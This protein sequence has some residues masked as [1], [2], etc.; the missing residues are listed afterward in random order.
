MREGIRWQNVVTFV[1]NGK[2]IELVNP[3]PNDKLI[4]YLKYKEN[5]H[6]TKLSCGEGGCGACT[7]VLCHRPQES[8]PEVAVEGSKTQENVTYRAVNACLFPVCALDG[9]EVITVEGIGSL[10]KGLHPI[11]QRLVETNGTQCGY[12]T[13][14]WVMNMYELLRKNEHSK[15]LITRKTVES[16]FD[17]NLCRCTG[18]RPILKAFHSFAI[19]YDN[20]T[21]QSSPALCY[22]GE[23]ESSLQQ[24]YHHRKDSDGLDDWIV[25]DTEST[26]GSNVGKCKN[27]A[28]G[29]ACSSIGSYCD[30]YNDLE[31]LLSF[32]SLELNAPYNTGNDIKPSDFV[33]NFKPRPL[34]FEDSKKKIKWYRPIQLDQIFW[35]LEEHNQ[36]EIMFIGGK[37]SVAVTKYYNNSYP[38]NQG[39]I[40]SV[41]VELN[42]IKE[43]KQLE[44]KESHAVV[45]AAVTIGSLLSFLKLVQT[46]YDPT[47]EDLTDLV[48][49]VANNQ[50][51]NTATWAGNLMMCR[52]H[53]DFVSD[54]V[55]GL[56]GMEATLSL[57][58]PKKQLQENVSIE[59]FLK[60]PLTEFRLIAALNLPFHASH[61]NEKISFK[62][63]KVAQRPVNAHS[64]VNCSIKMVVR[65]DQEPNICQG[66][67][68]VFGGVS[69]HPARFHHTEKYLTGT[70]INLQTLEIVLEKLE[71]D[72]KSI[73]E[74]TCFGSK[75]FR[76]SVMKNFLY[77]TILSSIKEVKDPAIASASE[78]L[79]RDFS[80][81]I[82][83]FK[84][85]ETTAPVSFPLQKIEAKMQATGEALFV[86]DKELNASA[87]Y[88]AMVYS[89]TALGTVLRI[90]SR[91]ALKM[92]GVVDIVTAEDIPG[93]NDVSG[94]SEEH[95]FVPIG[96]IVRCIGA[97]IAVILAKTPEIAE[98][99]A[100]KVIVDYGAVDKRSLWENQTG[101]VTNLDMA[102][103][104]GIL[105]RNDPVKIGD[106]LVEEKLKKCD[107]VI[108]GSL[109]LGSQKHFY[110]EPQNSTVSLQDGEVFFVE[111]SSQHPKYVQLQLANVL[112]VKHH[113]INVKVP[114]VGGG[115]GGKLTRCVINAAAA[116]VAA[117]KHRTTVRVLNNR[118]TDFQ[119]VG[120]REPI[121]GE[122]TVGFDKDG[123]IHA[124]DL[125]LRVDCGYIGGDSIGSGTMAVKW[126]DSAYSINSFR[127][128][129]F[130][131]LT[132]TQTN[133]ALRA[134][135]VPQSMMLVEAALSHVANVLHLPMKWIQE[136][137]LYKEGDHTP[138]GQRLT[139]VRMQEVWN[140]L[141]VSSHLEQREEA[142]AYFNVANKWKKRGI[143]M[144]PTKY[145][146]D[147]SGRRDGVRIEIFAADGSVILT[148]GGCEVGQGINTKALQVCAYE[149]GIPTSLIS[150]RP[151]STDKIPNSEATGGSTTSESVCRSVM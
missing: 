7:V 15:E 79:S 88:G 43:L 51:R 65:I 33:L 146:I 39:D 120:G 125:T 110:M 130:Y 114:R 49:R 144:T 12:C 150:V 70:A 16:H 147:Y 61:Q 31:D 137:N 97:P 4:D 75:D 81:G 105:A 124:M 136:R 57:M 60:M 89:S 145:G 126:S 72:L 8:L 98:A 121:K 141:L 149:L 53:P 151:T 37:T 45:G 1:L 96:G 129:A 99:A 28:C 50:V 113:T 119:L 74:S 25:V 69:K 123:Y 143:A 29:K 85:N 87:L 20:D 91:Y 58:D 38:Y 106:D 127:C 32:A 44:I 23:V 19:D 134:P 107:H 139:E 52:E 76:S 142:I 22:E 67:S 18:Y 138:Y 56:M 118:N 117:R 34:L 133:T 48:G 21:Q 10:T 17:G 5:L 73:G 131:Y 54:M 63:Y 36:N 66:C 108:R 116:A 112:N 148:H 128:R 46:Q 64:H 122:Y 132:N 86:T 101:P 90:D 41:Q 100:A 140:R 78:K 71:V 102:I 135:G 84:T 9:I 13:P 82:Q 115:F 47:Y 14:G 111:T 42:Y 103:K 35:I 24:R 95:L 104:A 6:G 59:D 109:P 26:N 27:N 2:K 93:K 62:T 94:K 55:V 77:K 80:N 83:T 92:D 11:Q 68:I 40:G 3:N 30:K